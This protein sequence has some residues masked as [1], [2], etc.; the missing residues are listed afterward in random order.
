MVFQSEAY[1]AVDGGSANS[2]GFSCSVGRGIGIDVAPSTRNS[3]F[4]VDSVVLGKYELRTYSQESTLVDFFEF[5]TFFI[6]LRRLLQ[7]ILYSNVF[8]KKTVLETKEYIGI[9]I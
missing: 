4:Y 9:Y 6:R 8:H 2:S 1:K 7:L 5:N 3:C